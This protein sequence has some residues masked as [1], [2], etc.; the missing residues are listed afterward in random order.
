MTT[1]EL[2]EL[3]KSVESLRRAIRINNPV[4]RGVA[5]SRLYAALSFPFGIVLIGF[6]VVA[7][8]A[9]IRYGSFAAVPSALKIAALSMALVLFASGAWVKLYFTNRMVKSLDSRSGILSMA[10]ILFG[11]KAAELVIAT[12]MSMAGAVVFAIS[13]GKAWYIVPVGSILISFTAF[14]LDLLIDLAEYRAMAWYSLV[15]GF[16]ALFRIE[17]APFLWTA[18]VLGGM[19]VCFGITGLLRPKMSAPTA[20]ASAQGSAPTRPKEYNKR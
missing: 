17:T 12:F 9:S 15:S 4:L 16:I 18:A 2:E 6:C 19:L 5:S 7:H 14:G 10:R 1:N 13:V 11:G 3:T 8:E 20:R